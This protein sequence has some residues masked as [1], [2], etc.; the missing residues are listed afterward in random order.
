MVVVFGFDKPL[1]FRLL[2]LP[3][4]CQTPA[5][6]DF[7]PEHPPDLGDSEGDSLSVLLLAELVVEE[8][9]L[10]GFGSEV[11]GLAAH[12]SDGGGEHQ[13]EGDRFGQ[14]VPSVGGNYLVLGE[15][16]VWL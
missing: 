16:L 15:D 12:R 3:H 1:N 5:R 9:T 13:V 10:R 2:E 11:A 8:N 6:C 7:V 14:R 4:P